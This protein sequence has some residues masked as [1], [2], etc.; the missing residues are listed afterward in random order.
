M[1]MKI[2]FEELRKKVG[3]LVFNI[4][5]GSI[6]YCIVFVGDDIDVYDGIDV[7]KFFLG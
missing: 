4:K 2:I 3:D 7:C 6:I 5:V 1:E